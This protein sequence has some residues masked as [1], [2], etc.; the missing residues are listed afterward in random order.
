LNR[1]AIAG[2]INSLVGYLLIFGLIFVGLEP[3]LSNVLGYAV[4]L[5]TSFFLNKYWVMG[6]TTKDRSQLVRFFVAFVIC[7][8]VSL[9]FLYGFIYQFEFDKYLSQLLS[10][11]VYF[12]AF[13]CFNKLYVFK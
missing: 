3:L 12:V 1:A 6:N 7:Y 10:G 9:V 11:G 2:L 13:F 8:G 5:V 4:G